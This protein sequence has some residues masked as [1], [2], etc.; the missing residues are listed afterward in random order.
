MG[1]V[2]SGDGAWAGHHCIT[3]R[4]AVT[5]AAVMTLLAERDPVVK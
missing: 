4:V 5:G 2:Q 3:G 1:V